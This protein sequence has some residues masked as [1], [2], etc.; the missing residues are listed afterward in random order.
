M[1]FLSV[2]HFSDIPE[3]Q[4]QIFLGHVLRT[5]HWKQKE[6]SPFPSTELSTHLPIPCFCSLKALGKSSLCSAASAFR[7]SFWLL[8]SR[9]LACKAFF[10][11]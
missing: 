3:W 10:T 8:P 2:L 7:D 4:T 5:N 1:I 9:T 6:G 11:W